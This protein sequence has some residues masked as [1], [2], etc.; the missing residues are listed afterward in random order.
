ML[1]LGIGHSSHWCIDIFFVGPCKSHQPQVKLV[2]VVTPWN[3][4]LNVAMFRSTGEPCTLLGQAVKPHSSSIVSTMQSLK[5]QQCHNI[6][7]IFLYLNQ[8]KSGNLVICAGKK[9]LD[10]CTKFLCPIWVSWL[11]FSL[12]FAQ[13]R[14]KICQGDMDSSY[15]PKYQATQHTSGC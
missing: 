14:T 3:H 9:C 13:R 10:Q 1:W 11:N 4:R 15:Q 5:W 8:A 6:C 7:H 12:Y 2:F